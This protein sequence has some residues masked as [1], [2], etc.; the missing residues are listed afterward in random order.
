MLLNYLSKLTDAE[1][2]NDWKILSQKKLKVLSEGIRN[3]I[4]F[5]KKANKKFV[6][7]SK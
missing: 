3:F 1:T 5:Q 6:N 4:N 7:E 2:L